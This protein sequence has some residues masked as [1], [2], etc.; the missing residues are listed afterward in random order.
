MADFEIELNNTP[1]TAS[2]V[3]FGVETG[4]QIYSPADLDYFSFHLDSASSVAWSFGSTPK[5]GGLKVD[6]FSSNDLLKPLVTVIKDDPQT[7]EYSSVFF[8]SSAGTYY[9][10][11]SSISLVD[12]AYDSGQYSL[13][14]DLS[15]KLAEDENGAGGNDSILTAN[16]LPADVEMV[17]QLKSST[18]QDFFKVPI[19]NT[20]VWTVSFTSPLETDD[21]LSDSFRISVY[22]ADGTLISS[23]LTDLSLDFNF[24]ASINDNYF[25][26]VDSPVDWHFEDYSLRVSSGI[27]ANIVN[28]GSE[29]D[30][31]LGT[32]G[33]DV[34]DGG[35]GDDVMKGGAGDDTYIVDSKKDKIIENVNEGNDS[36]KTAL[37][38][39]F[40]PSNVENLAL[41]GE[42]ISG[43]GNE[44]NNFLTGNELNNKLFGQDGNDSIDGGAGDDKMSGGKGDDSYYVDSSL[45]KIIESANSG[46]DVVYTKI[47]L[48]KLA[49]NVEDIVLLND[50]TYATG[51]K[52]A[53]DIVGNNDFNSIKGMDGND[54]LDGGAGNDELRG[55][56][57]N[58]ELTGGSGNDF[59]IFDTALSTSNNLDSIQDF[60]IGIDKIMLSHKIFSNL[61]VGALSASNF[62]AGGLAVQDGDDKIIYDSNTETLYFDKDASGG[63]APVAFIQLTING[64]GVLTEA[65]FVI[66]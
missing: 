3:K 16:D 62:Q 9:F 13:A 44:L 23:H 42:A 7:D 60:E 20:G 59:F 36:V 21:V 14:I 38:N 65:D 52:S 31:L 28:G 17:G 30:N 11:V 29:N 33:N 58:D 5:F 64:A 43:K 26:S 51:N 46:I 2:I 63:S 4:G 25:I 34:I 12:S 45:D 37:D 54:S 18:D 22:Y 41:L 19:S 56:K 39:Y 15:S 1:A 61:P 66:A 47:D 35:A 49:L 24:S 57:G 40:L 32:V 48:F 27:Q 55:G 6:I 53:N 8:A 50:A 10:Q